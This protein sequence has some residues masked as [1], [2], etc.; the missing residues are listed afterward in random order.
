LSALLF[1]YGP[2]Y[3]VVIA[4]ET[5]QA[6]TQTMLKE[7]RKGYQPHKVVLLREEN[8]ESWMVDAVPVLASQLPIDGKT[9]AYV[10]RDF[11]CSA[12]T[13]DPEKMIN[14]LEKE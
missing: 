14:L 9:T 3:E 5:D 4:G 11:Q 12:P 2:S 7:L 8:V 13:T 1:V 6:S 10:C